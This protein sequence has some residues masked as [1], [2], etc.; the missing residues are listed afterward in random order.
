MAGK[1][2]VSET[3]I[4]ML[5]TLVV[6]LFKKRGKSSASFLFEGVFTM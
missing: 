5:F 2:Y 4:D 3:L 6:R 1:G